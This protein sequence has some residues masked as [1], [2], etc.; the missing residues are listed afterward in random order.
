MVG[1]WRISLELQHGTQR[2]C[3]EIMALHE[4]SIRAWASNNWKEHEKV[5]KEIFTMRK[6]YD[7][8][9]LPFTKQEMDSIP[10]FAAGLP[11]WYSLPN[12][13]LSEMN[14]FNKKN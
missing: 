12:D 7:R 6:K 11:T 8:D 3:I 13:Y 2:K 10:D 14:H 4:K 5:N 9:L 1:P